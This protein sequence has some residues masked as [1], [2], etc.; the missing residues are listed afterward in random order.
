MW[1]RIRFI[2]IFIHFYAVCLLI[3]ECWQIFQT[4][5]YHNSSISSGFWLRR[6]KKNNVFL[7]TKDPKALHFSVVVHVWRIE[8]P[9]DTYT[10]SAGSLIV[11]TDT[12]SYIFAWSFSPS[13]LPLILDMIALSNFLSNL[14]PYS[15][16]SRKVR[17]SSVS[18]PVLLSPVGKLAIIL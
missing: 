13:L 11:T 17:T 16:E 12:S 4:N 9:S 15:N 14:C 10:S 8:K 2:P 5:I 3:A 1:Q 7:S 18:L 6:T